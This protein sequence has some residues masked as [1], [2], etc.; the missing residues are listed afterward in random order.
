M[1]F[2]H[3]LNLAWLGGDRWNNGLTSPV[4]VVLD[5]RLLGQASNCAFF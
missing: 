4:G 2:V 1:H 5:A 3:A